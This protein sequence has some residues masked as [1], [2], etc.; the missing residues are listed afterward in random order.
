[1]NFK[2]F[3][4]KGNDNMI[5][6][7]FKIYF[8]NLWVNKTTCDLKLYLKQFDDNVKYNVTI[9]HIQTGHKVTHVK[10]KIDSKRG[11]IKNGKLLIGIQSLFKD[12]CWKW[13]GF[14]GT[15][16][17]INRFLLEYTDDTVNKTKKDFNRLSE[18]NKQYALGQIIEFTAHKENVKSNDKYNEVYNEFCGGIKRYNKFKYKSFLGYLCKGLNKTDELFTFLYKKNPQYCDIV[19]EKIYSI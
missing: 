15:K 1:M 13:F 14:I 16:A 6:N 9:E 12:S 2:N 3:N 10:C 8:K 19:V 18:A 11:I 17:N 7:G 5:M 4:K